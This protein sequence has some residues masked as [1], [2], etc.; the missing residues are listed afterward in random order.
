MNENFWKTALIVLTVSS[1]ILTIYSILRNQKS[2]KLQDKS[3][4]LDI[5][6]KTYQLSKV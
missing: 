3:N 4:E 5:E 6:L 2:L 1:I